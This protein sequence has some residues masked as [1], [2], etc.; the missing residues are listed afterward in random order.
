MN[1]GSVLSTATT[2]L[3]RN[4]RVVHETATKIVQQPVARTDKTHETID[5]NAEIIQMKQAEI[6][7]SAN[8]TV[9]RTADDMTA[10]L[11]DVLA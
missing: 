9:I 10:T 6:A 2:G 7:Y 11:L 1:I 8:A 5:L 4:A 3:H